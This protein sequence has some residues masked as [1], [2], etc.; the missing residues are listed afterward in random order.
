MN[1]V[2]SCGWLEYFSGGARSDFYACAIEDVK[3]L[4]VPS[5]CLL[6]VFKKILRERGEGSALQAAALMHQG[7]VIDLDDA[8]ALSA[9]KLSV[10]HKLPLAD[11]I[12]FATARAHAA[13]IWTQDG[14]FEGLPNVKF[15]KK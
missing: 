7:L 9:A 5:V 10:E 15:L 6:E 14:D 3:K 13:T 12:V 2:D 1:V 11:S 4:V 8:L